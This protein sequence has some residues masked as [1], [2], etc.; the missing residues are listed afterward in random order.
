MEGGLFLLTEGGGG[1]DGIAY[2]SIVTFGDQSQVIFI[3]LIYKEIHYFFDH[4]RM[5]V[6]SKKG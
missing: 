3:F 1:V 2:V 6:K 5:H 4:C